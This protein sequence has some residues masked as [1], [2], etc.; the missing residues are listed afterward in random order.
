VVAFGVY[1]KGKIWVEVLVGFADR[2]DLVDC[3]ARE[4]CGHHGG[5]LR[6]LA[7]AENVVKLL[8]SFEVNF[9]DRE[10]SERGW[11]WRSLSKDVRIYDGALASGWRLKCGGD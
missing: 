7:R 4:G 6:I 5:W 10:R 8:D 2:A 3:A 1:D 9:S 11:L